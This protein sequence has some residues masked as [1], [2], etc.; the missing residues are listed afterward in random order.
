[1]GFFIALFFIWIPC[2]IYCGTT[3]EDKGHNGF[4][5]FWAGLLFGPIGLIAV[6]GLSDRKQRR[7]I[8][9]MAE[10]QGVNLTDD[11]EPKRAVDV[12]N[13]IIKEKR[14]GKSAVDAFLEQPK[15]PADSDD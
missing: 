4:S 6:A 3:S 9:L 2:A 1:M 13:D 8:R 15:M 5:W 14:Q 11:G 7:Y 12:A 10:N